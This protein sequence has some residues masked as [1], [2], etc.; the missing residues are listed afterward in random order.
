L[1]FVGF[2]IVESKYCIN[3]IVRQ[4]SE[5]V[6]NNIEAVYTQ[7]LSEHASASLEEYKYLVRSSLRTL[8]IN[9]GII[10]VK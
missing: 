1:Y 4:Y 7:V 8:S 2:L 10:F 3:K 9:V 6:T 5:Q